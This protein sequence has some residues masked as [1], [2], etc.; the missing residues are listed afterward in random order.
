M[1]KRKSVI[2][3]EKKYFTFMLGC[4]SC[5]QLYLQDIYAS[6]VIYASPVTLWHTYIE[7][8][9]KKK[10]KKKK[11]CGTTMTNRALDNR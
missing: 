6:L 5:I 9:T 10:L 3:I 1:L 7:T 8:T 2:I 4:V 11:M